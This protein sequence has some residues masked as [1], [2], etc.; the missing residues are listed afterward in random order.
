MDLICHTGTLHIK[1]WKRFFP[2]CDYFE[3]KLP[4]LTALNFER[5]SVMSDG[6]SQLERREEFWVEANVGLL[7]KSIGSV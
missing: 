3:P 5:Q 6:F 7:E 4:S 1:K 2:F